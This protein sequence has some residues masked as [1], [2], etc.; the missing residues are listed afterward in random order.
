MSLDRFGIFS[1]I[2]DS[3][4]ETAEVNDITI[5]EE[6]SE[7]TPLYGQKGLLDSIALVGLT[8]SVEESLSKMG[9]NITIASDKAFSRKTSPFLNVRTLANF[10]EELL[11][12]QDN[13]HHGDK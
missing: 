11:N 12:G 5:E 8:A 7:R 9:Y 4:K 10:I 6:I 1:V 3:L 2:R 13:S